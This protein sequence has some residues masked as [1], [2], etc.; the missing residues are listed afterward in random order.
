MKRARLRVRVVCVCVCFDDK[1]VDESNQCL[2]AAAH[3]STSTQQRAAENELVSAHFD[4]CGWRGQRQ[5]LGLDLQ[6]T[7]GTVNELFE[8]RKRG[9]GEQKKN[10]TRT[11]HE[12]VLLRCANWKTAKSKKKCCWGLYLSILCSGIQDDNGFHL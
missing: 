4:G 8:G 1:Q 2:P 12:Q 10:P 11:N 7:N 9:K 6:L 5:E 3:D